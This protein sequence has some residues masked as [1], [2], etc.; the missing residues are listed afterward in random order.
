MA[1]K[2]KAHGIFCLEGEWWNNLKKESS[3]ES[4][5]NLLSQWDPFFVPYIRR[6]VG[7]VVELG[8]YLDKWVQRRHDGFPILYLAFHG[9]KGKII[10]GDSRRQESNLTIDQLEEHLAGKCRKRILYLAACD[11]LG[12]H[13]N[14]LNRFLRETE[15]LAVCGYTVGAD[16]LLAAAFELVV[17]G[18]M[19]GNAL[20]RPGVRSMRR[21]I[22]AEAPQLR[23]K[24][25]F[26]MVTQ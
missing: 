22:Y 25:G 18:T 13:G 7:T 3:V 17:F 2:R 21:K 15:A 10:V 6:D 23:E 11:T 1:R 9:E 26:R 19:Q 20:T 24:L 16:W 4:I 14:R 5:L 12:V 8:Y